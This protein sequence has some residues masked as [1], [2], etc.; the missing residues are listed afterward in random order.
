VFRA[1]LPAGIGDAA[2]QAG[3]GL[4]YLEAHPNRASA[5]L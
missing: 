1:T 4:L 2:A 3:L 5:G